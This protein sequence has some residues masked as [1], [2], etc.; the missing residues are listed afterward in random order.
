MD[1][2]HCHEKWMDDGFTH[3]SNL[4]YHHH[5]RKHAFKASKKEGREEGGMRWVCEVRAANFY[6][7]EGE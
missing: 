7:C 3:T 6:E 1:S 2:W 5:Y 4:F